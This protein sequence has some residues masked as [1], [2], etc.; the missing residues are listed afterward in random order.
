[1]YILRVIRKLSN[2]VN[3]FKISLLKKYKKQMHWST[4]V[5]HATRSSLEQI[6]PLTFF[7]LFYLHE[8]YKKI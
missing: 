7:Y 2:T 1:M 8:K 6:E 3:C 5:A 4:H